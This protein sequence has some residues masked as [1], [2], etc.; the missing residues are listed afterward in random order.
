M[1]LCAC[2]ACLAVALLSI[3]RRC[4]N[5]SCLPSSTASCHETFPRT[6]KATSASFRTDHSAIPDVRGLLL[7][8]DGD[9]ALFSEGGDSVACPA[10]AAARVSS[11]AGRGLLLA[12]ADAVF[13]C[14]A[15]RLRIFAK[16]LSPP[17][18]A[19]TA[20]FCKSSSLSLFRFSSSFL[21]SSLSAFS[22]FSISASSLWPSSLCSSTDAFNL[23]QRREVKDFRCSEGPSK[24]R[25]TVP[26]LMST[27]KSNRIPLSLAVSISS[28]S[29]STNFR[30]PVR[31]S[32]A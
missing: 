12:E 10:A 22:F 6:C 13:V 28:V 4:V 16:D 29:F 32:S 1:L 9:G 11:D 2:P 23:W 17:S 18:L 8:G 3:T 5:A 24:R 26:A 27:S 25:E 14:L 31:D 21:I 30:I 15:T 20:F 19:A 7:E